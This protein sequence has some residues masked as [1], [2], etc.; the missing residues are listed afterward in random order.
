M[1]EERRHVRNQINQ[2]DVS[3][4][5]PPD[6]E[7]TLIQKLVA[8]YLAHEGYVET[9]KAFA[10]DVRD[11][12]QNLARPEERS[13][14][15]LELSGEDDMHTLNRQKIRR[16]I[17]DGDI[18]RALKYT[19][20][21]YPAVLQDKRNEGIYF[22]LRC[23]KFVEMMRKYSELQVAGHPETGI[24]SNGHNNED[25]STNQ[26]ELDDQLTRE[27]TKQSH[28]QPHSAGDEDDIE[29]TTST[30]SLLPQTTTSAKLSSTSPSNSKKSS[31]Y[32]TEALQ[33]GQELQAEFGTDPRPHVKEQLREVFA[34]MAYVDPKG[35]I[36]GGL[37]DTKGRVG[38]AEGVNAAV[39]GKFHVK[40]I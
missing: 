19:H 37:L 28:L 9:S 7:N 16:A 36:V 12:V 4:L 35:S 29:M 21:F 14:D 40:C 8:Q 18:D 10:T 15:L 20:T 2:T 31:D 17:L 3:R 6:D 13:S 22:Q 24:G 1:A 32:L 39:L 33:Y 27:S 26:M 25:D 23:R 11:R 30:S 38:I 34:I 5:H